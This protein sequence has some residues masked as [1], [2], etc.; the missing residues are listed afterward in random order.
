MT[1]YSKKTTTTE[2]HGYTSQSKEANKGKHTPL[3]DEQNDEENRS[4][5]TTT[6]DLNGKETSSQDQVYFKTTYQ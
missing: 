4:K 3:T 2:V 6:A 5:R 1:K